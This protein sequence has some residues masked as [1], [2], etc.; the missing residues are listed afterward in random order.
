MI[1]DH[2]VI[3]PLHGIDECNQAARFQDRIWGEGFTERV[4]A[5]LLKVVPRIGGVSLGAFLRNGGGEGEDGDMVGLVFG[6]T[7]VEEDRTVHWS[8]ILGVDPKYRDQGV[9]R[10]LKWAQRQAAIEAGATRMYWTFD[11]LEA[12][13]AWVNLERLGAVV[14][15]YVPDMY[16]VSESPIHRGLGTDRL[17]AMW[18]LM[19][20]SVEL[21]SPSAEVADVAAP[22]A[23]GEDEAEGWPEPRAIV[24]PRLTD[25]P[26][27]VPIPS[28]IQALRDADPALAARWREQTRGILQ[29]LLE[30]GAEIRGFERGSRICEYVVHPSRQDHPP[31]SNRR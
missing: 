15:E 13:N 2:I 23:S 26:V 10:R 29:P 14:R 7:G 20:P 1:H 9:G 27:R 4:P 5:S 6:I 3:R 21:R 25:E 24:Y 11:P 19:A 8:D 16:G 31:I 30:A 22:L 28:D 12:R 17:I 18:P